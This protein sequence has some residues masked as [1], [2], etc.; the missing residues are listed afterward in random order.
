MNV[1]Q[2]EVPRLSELVPKCLEACDTAY[3][4]HSK[5]QVGCALVARNE[6]GDERLFSGCN[7]ENASLGAT[8]CAERT[9]MVK[10]I[11]EGY[12]QF[13]TVMVTSVSSDQF[14]APCGIFRQFMREFGTDIRVILLNA[15]T[16]QLK[17][18]TLDQLL[19]E[20]FGPGAF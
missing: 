17:S 2:K 12:T 16:K 15:K 5:F 8:I 20:S 3:V 19:P 18:F 11:S 13:P 6:A 9:A 4:P 7:V 1:T 14:V 10:A